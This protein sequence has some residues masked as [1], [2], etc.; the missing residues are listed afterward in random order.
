[1]LLTA[2]RLL[3]GEFRRTSRRGLDPRKRQELTQS[4]HWRPAIWAPEN[5][6]RCS[7]LHCR[8]R[9][10]AAGAGPLIRGALL[11]T[12]VIKSSILERTILRIGDGFA[13]YYP[14]TKST[15]RAWPVSRRL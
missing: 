15:V 8:Y 10:A 11:D 1:M 3:S 9:A 13:L 4:R 7:G 2:P 6:P 14:T 5:R 12:R